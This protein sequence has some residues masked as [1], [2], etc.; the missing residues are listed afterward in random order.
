MYEVPP[1]STI[2]DS[3]EKIPQKKAG[4]FGPINLTLAVFGPFYGEIFG[5]FLWRG[6]RGE[7]TPIPLTFFVK[8]IFR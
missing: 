2:L 7:G 5:N 3:K 4:N 8:K 1:N 6:G